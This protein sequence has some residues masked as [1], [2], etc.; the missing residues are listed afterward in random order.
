[1][2]RGGA[3]R[4]KSSQEARTGFMDGFGEP[5]WQISNDHRVFLSMGNVEQKNEPSE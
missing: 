1:M 4:K 3:L 2:P 5:P